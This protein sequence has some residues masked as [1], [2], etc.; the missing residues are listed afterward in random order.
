MHKEATARVIAM[1]TP[2]LTVAKA[3][4]VHQDRLQIAH[5][6]TDVH[7]VCYNRAMIIFLNGF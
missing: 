5:M 4:I 1:C 6:I 2:M 7:K 3:T